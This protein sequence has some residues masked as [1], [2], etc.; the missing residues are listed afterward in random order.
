MYVFDTL[1]ILLVTLS[2]NV[3]FPGDHLKHLGFRV[4]KQHRRMAS[5]PEAMGLASR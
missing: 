2:Y 4:P 3:Y 5:D 1:P